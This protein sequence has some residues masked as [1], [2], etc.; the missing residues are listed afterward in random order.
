MSIG[1][2]Q[3]IREENVH[4]NAQVKIVDIIFKKKKRH[5]KQIN[6]RCTTEINFDYE[7]FDY[8]ELLYLPSEVNL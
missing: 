6:V 3:V 2:M 5:K 7:L 1:Q 4:G 8:F